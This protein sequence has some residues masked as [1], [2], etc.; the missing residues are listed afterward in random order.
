MSAPAEMAA[1]KHHTAQICT[2]AL[3]IWMVA[4]LGAYLYQFRDL[5]GPVLAV[6]KAGT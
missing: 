6:L 5:V 4:A 1:Y 3:W 2:I